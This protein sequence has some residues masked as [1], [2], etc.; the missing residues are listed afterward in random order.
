MKRNM[1]LILLLIVNVVVGA[2]VLRSVDKP[3]TSDD[4]EFEDVM[5]EDLEIISTSIYTNSPMRT[6]VQL[7]DEVRESLEELRSEQRELNEK[8]QFNDTYGVT[9][10]LK[11]KKEDRQWIFFDYQV[12]SK[13]NYANTG[14]PQGMGSAE[15]VMA[16]VVYDTK[17]EQIVEIEGLDFFW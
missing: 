11:K 12:I 7:S 16:S 1:I 10:T 15:S 3:V 8:Y 2:V 13:W 6:K 5:I 4:P 9:V 17:E 14:V